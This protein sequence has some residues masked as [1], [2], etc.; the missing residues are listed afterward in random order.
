[1]RPFKS[2]YGKATYEWHTGDI[3]VHT[4]NEGMTY[5]YIWVTYRW[6]TSTYELHTNETQVHTNDI[7][8]TYEYIRLTYESHK[9]Y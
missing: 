5:E 4:S 8:M 6:H 1:M 3:P 9:K 2:V 7:R